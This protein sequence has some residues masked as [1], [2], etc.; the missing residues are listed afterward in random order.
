MVVPLVIAHR[1]ASAD[2]P[3]HTAAAYAM[4]VEH[5]ADAIELD[6]R[7]TADDALVCVH[8][9]T[10]ERTGGLDRPVAESTVAQLRTL[11]VG[12]WFSSDFA[13]ERVLTLDEAIEVVPDHVVLYLELKD[14]GLHGG[15]AEEVLVATLEDHGRLD[16]DRTVF[17][18]FDAAAL[19]TLRGLV[20]EV[21]TSLAWFRRDEA[22]LRGDLPA[23]VDISAPN[24]FVL[25]LAE[26][27]VDAVH[28]VGREVHVWTVDERDEV[29]AVVAAGVDG[30]FTNR[31]GTVR[32]L[33]AGIGTDTGA[34]HPGSS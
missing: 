29:A 26:D 7:L 23:W 16:P 10:F 24:T 5:G 8:D 12:S 11:D 14:P 21:P 33:L 13:G 34:P 31:P 17:E 18:S 4:A 27:H 20:P 25:F 19:R 32:S 2:A 22:L 9:P 30:L 6:L 15:R 1:G 28:A 3:E